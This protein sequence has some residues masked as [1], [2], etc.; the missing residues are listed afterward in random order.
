M[1]GIGF[2]NTFFQ[3]KMTIIELMCEFMQ[4]TPGRQYRSGGAKTQATLLRYA[5]L[6]RITGNQRNKRN[7]LSHSK[8]Q[9]E[10]DDQEIESV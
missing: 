2:D 1:R 3:G 10:I 6:D 8:R 4:G 5:C 9:S 7:R